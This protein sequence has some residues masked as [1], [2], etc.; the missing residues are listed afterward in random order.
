MS[1]EIRKCINE[2]NRGKG[3]E[4]L[5]NSYIKQYMTLHDGFGRTKMMLEYYMFYETISE[6][7]NPYIDTV[8]DMANRFHEMVNTV[9]EKSPSG[10]EMEKIGNELLTI[11]QEIVDR[12][13]VLTAYVDCFVIYEYILNRVQYRFEDQEMMP[14]DNEFAQK[15]MQFIFSSED[16]VTIGENVRFVLGQLPMRLTRTRYFDLIREAVSVYKGSEKSALD[17]FIYMF[18]TNAML[19]Q[20]ANKEKYFTEF[21]D[22]L[23]ELESIDYEN[24]TAELYTIYAEKIRTNAAKLNDISD[25]YL[26]LTG[27][28]NELY[29]ICASSPYA[30]ALENDDVT[31]VV[32]RGINSLFLQKDSD[33]WSAM[34]SEGASEEEK[35]YWLGEQ[36]TAIEGRQERLF[37]GMDMAG[38]VLEETMES[39]KNNIMEYHFEKEF[40]LLKQ[41]FLLTSNSVFADLHEKEEEETVTPEMADQV[42]QELVQD[43]KKLFEGKSRMLRRAIMANTLEHMP[44]FFTS[45]QEIADYVMAALS[46]CDDDAEKYAAKQLLLDVIEG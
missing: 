40:Q 41:M 22:V 6:G 32:I 2:L 15:L 19:Y 33:V 38:A 30:D 11:R 28:I 5:L 7:I 8:S 24:I 12:M 42:T 20:S 4:E 13:E 16:N 9:F 17:G 1:S 36:F 23:K 27:L 10:E 3:T 21:A 46:Q 39:Q 37:E 14:G 18:R 34:E 43:L 26:Q 31:G 35:L 25:L 29:C 44:V 45:G